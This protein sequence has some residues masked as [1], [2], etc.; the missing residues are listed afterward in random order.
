MYRV[1]ETDGSTFTL[2]CFIIIYHHHHHYFIDFYHVRLSEE[3]KAKFFFTLSEGLLWFLASQQQE[4]KES[5]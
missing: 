2:L 4:I 3:R 5:C 1:P